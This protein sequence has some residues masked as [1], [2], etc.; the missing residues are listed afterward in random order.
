MK[1]RLF[2]I[3]NMLT[4]SNLLCGS[5]AIVCTATHNNLTLAFYFVVGAMLFDFLDGFAARILKQISPI[6][7]VLDSLSDLVSFGLAPS[8]ILF[9]VINSSSLSTGVVLLDNWGGY[10]AF[11][12]TLFSSLRLARFSVE[13]AENEL[14]RG[15][16]TPACG[17]LISSLGLLFQSRGLDLGVTL[18]IVLAIV[19]SYLLISDVP[20]L[21]LKFKSFSLKSNIERYL[22]LAISAAELIILQ[23][24]AIPV[25]IATYILFSIVMR[26]VKI[27]RG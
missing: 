14:F 6:G 17:V 1:S 11:I 24:Y 26:F 9:E 19:L 10:I 27:E 2:T 15:M 25:I 12:V 21:T 13:D 18:Y 8:F 22:F 23:L 20:M 7:V 3:P 5:L 4:L 16:P